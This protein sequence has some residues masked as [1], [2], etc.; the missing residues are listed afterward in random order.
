MRTSPGKTAAQHQQI[1]YFDADGSVQRAAT[2]AGNNVNLLVNL[3]ILNYM[4][5]HGEEGL[6]EG[7]FPNHGLGN[8]A[9]RDSLT[10]FVPFTIGS[11]AVRLSRIAAVPRP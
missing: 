11:N 5:L 2:P 7:L 10:A 3:T 6:F 4:A 9:M 1:G 8:A